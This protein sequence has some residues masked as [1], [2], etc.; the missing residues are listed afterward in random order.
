MKLLQ[1]MQSETITND[2]DD[3]SSID[4]EWSSNSFDITNDNDEK[5]ENELT[6]E[7]EDELIKQ[8]H[9]WEQKVK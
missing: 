3:N 9:A 6:Q 7:Y 2:N 5:D 8:K 4:I 1:I